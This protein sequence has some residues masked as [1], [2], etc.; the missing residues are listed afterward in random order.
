MYHCHIQGTFGASIPVW[1]PKKST[2]KLEQ[3]STQKFF[4]QTGN[5]LITL[6][7][8][9]WKLDILDTYLR[10]KHSM[11][12]EKHGDFMKKTFNSYLNPSVPSFQKYNR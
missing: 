12:K 5:I 8:I 6:C 2:Q 1:G 11:V 4:Y 3:Y 9:Y 7:N 10:I